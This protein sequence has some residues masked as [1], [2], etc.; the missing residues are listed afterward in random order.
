MEHDAF[1][2]IISG[3]FLFIVVLVLIFFK[4]PIYQLLI[5][6]IGA[7]VLGLFITLLILRKKKHS[8]QLQK[9]NRI[10]LKTTIKNA[11]PFFLSSLFVYIYYYADQI[12]LF[13]MKDAQSVGIYSAAYR[14]LTLLIS[15]VGIF[16]TALLPTFAKHFDGQSITSEIRNVIMINVRRILIWSLCLFTLLMIFS[17][18][19]IH[20]I[21]GSQYDRAVPILRLLLISWVLLINY[22]IFVIALQA[23]NQQKLYYYI[24]LV[25]A[26]LNV[27]LN[28]S[29][30][31]TYSITGSAIATVA[32]EFIVGALVSFYFFKKVWYKC[33]EEKTC[34]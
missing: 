14:I 22:S 19:I 30:I 12:L 28:V 3:L 17:P 11:A 4:S 26:I 23:F 13:S 34:I 18:Q 31:P 24:T 8:S 20:I 6:Y 2:Q 27:V 16:L 5:G 33:K 7:A 32:T 29:L 21:Y 1:S 15:P 10:G 9:I 25:G